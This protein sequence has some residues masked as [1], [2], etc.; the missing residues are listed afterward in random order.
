MNDFFES[1]KLKSSPKEDFEYEIFYDQNDKK[2]SFITAYVGE[3]SNVVIPARIDHCPMLGIGEWAFSNYNGLERVVIPNGVE[4]I[5]KGA[6]SGCR[7]LIKVIIPNSVYLIDEYAFYCCR[8]LENIIISDSVRVIGEEAFSGC[9]S[10]EFLKIP[11]S[12][13]FIEESIV[14]DCDNLEWVYIKK[15]W[16]D[17]EIERIFGENPQFKIFRTQQEI[18]EYLNSVKNPD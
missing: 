15:S 11:D 18:A 16:S 3:S 8:S 13:E 14:K 7:N 1:I 2:K 6:F 4:D 12:V 10:L 17:L 5:G 9:S